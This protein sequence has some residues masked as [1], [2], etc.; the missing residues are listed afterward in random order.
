MSGVALVAL[1]VLCFAGGYI[2]V[3]SLFTAFEKKKP[4][5]T[6]GQPPFFVPAEHFRAVLALRA[7]A[8]A[9]ELEDS[10]RRKH[11][12]YAALAAPGTDTDIRNVAQRKLEEVEDAYGYFRRNPNRL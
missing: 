12:E 11:A 10:Y 5:A 9:E 4:A 8:G 6:V 1:V 3:N 7:G 2:L